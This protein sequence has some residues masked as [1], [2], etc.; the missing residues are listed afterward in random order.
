MPFVSVPNV[1]EGQ[2]Q[3]LIQRMAQ[4]VQAAHT[5]VLDIHSDAIHNRSVFTLTGPPA[6]LREG[7]TAL[8]EIA[9]EIRLDHHEGVHPRLGG[10]DVCPVIPYELPMHAAVKLARSIGDSIHKATGL[11]IYFYGEAADRE[12]TRELRDIRRGGL[13]RLVRRAAGPLPPDLGGHVDPRRG[14]VCVGARGPLIAFNVN[15]GSTLPVAKEIAR[16]IREFEGGLPGVRALAFPIA[17]GI[18]Q[19]S[20]NL[21]RP[22]RAGID[23]AFE[24]IAT[25]ATSGGTEILS[26]EVVG[27]VPR[28]FLPDPTKQAARLLTQPD[29]CLETRLG[30]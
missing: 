12:E 5:A 9:A 14:V 29:L 18:S 2:N 11:P 23:A 19:I 4:V 27:L 30:V 28:R 21:T 8:A 25:L 26:C 15:L 3:G 13:E 22:E 17:P 16:S 6:A 20:M 7:V 1:S 24:M 10:L